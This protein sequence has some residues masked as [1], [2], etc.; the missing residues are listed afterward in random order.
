MSIAVV[1]GHN[2]FAKGFGFAS[3]P[4]TPATPETLY[5]VGSTSKAHTA[6]TLAQLIDTKAYPELSRGWTTPISSIIRDDFVLQDEWATNHITLDDAVSHLTGMSHHDN[7]W[8]REINGT[9]VTLKDVV[10]NLRNLPLSLEP[11]VEWHYCNLMYVTLSHVIESL[12]GKWLGDVMKDLIWDPLGMKTTYMNLDDAKNAPVPLA[13]SY[14]WKEEEKKYKEMPFMP[15]TEV[16]GAGAIISNVLDYAKWLK[17]LIHEAEPFSKAVH[18]D[19]RTPRSI[20][21]SDLGLDTDIALYGLAWMRTLLYG[22]VTYTH[23]G[24]TITYGASVYWLPDLKYGVVAFANGAES[25]NEAE[26]VI[27][28]KVIGDK[29][30]IPPSEREDIGKRL[31]E[32]REQAARD[33]KNADEILF[34]NR[35]KHA[36][37]HS[38]ATSQLTGVYHDQGYGTIRLYEEP[39]PDKANETILVA[40]RTELTWQ[41]QFRLHHV[42]GDYWTVY[43]KY[44]AGLDPV[45]E[46]Q[47]G[48]FKIGVD[49]KVSSLEVD[50]NDRGDVHQ[51]AILFNKID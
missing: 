21:N 30:Q 17:C 20:A 11:R 23:E 31:K 5:Y 4:D 50:F 29:L 40:D 25:S 13:R 39:N 46:F 12:T 41:Q 43:I 16:S 14:L 51:G 32:I 49:G 28:R 3:F 37:P 42:S 48:E 27:L 33:L 8:H 1:D 9:Q 26:A 7:S 15:I 34:P 24:S 36:L 18:N 10:R 2:V 44:L 19:I 22:A 38:V 45:M 6:A 47:T 35:P